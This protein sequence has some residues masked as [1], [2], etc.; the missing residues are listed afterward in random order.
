MRAVSFI[1]GS[2]ILAAATAASLAASPPRQTIAVA[3]GLSA[4]SNGVDCGH[5][6]KGLG[7][8]H[9]DAKLHDARFYI[10]APALIDRA[11]REVPIQ[12][13]QNDWQY[14]DTALLNFA[15][16]S[17]SC[18]GMTALNDSVKGT[19]PPGDY[20]GFTFVVGVPSLAKGEDGKDIVLN[21]SN[22]ATAPAPLDIQAMAWNWLAGRKFVK[23]E[24]DPEGGVTRPPLP[25]RSVQTAAAAPSQTTDAA[26]NSDPSKSDSAKSD[27]PEAA[28]VNADG[29]V[30]VS[31][32]M[33]H[34]GSTGCKGDPLT[35]EIISC[36]SAN[37]I[38]VRFAAFDPQKQRVVLDLE[39][40]FNGVDLNRD[41]GGA[42][43]CMSGP[44]DPEC[45]P[46][47][48]RLGLNLK[49]TAPDANDAGK[50]SKTGIQIF[51]VD[52]KRLT[53]TKK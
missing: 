7:K 36:A 33:L 30:T 15:D 28:R 16:R 32:W 42:T 11:G 25:R 34:L 41:A 50:P 38:P 29:T 4:G 10:S 26:A 43:G 27:P 21:H 37:R 47:F 17:R 23:I 8:T 3:F 2:T 48:E 14:A 40:L 53:A 22:F 12:L 24:V 35:G 6:I 20:R 49:E 1:F 46:I 44:V 5:E 18:K 19:V 39:S 45:T 51:R 13:D 52:S 9:V 31:T